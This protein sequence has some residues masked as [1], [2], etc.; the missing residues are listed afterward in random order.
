MSKTAKV[1]TVHPC[2]AWIDAGVMEEEELCPECFKAVGVKS[3]YKIIC[4]L[5]KQPAGATVGQLTTLLGLQQPTVT[6]HLNILKSIK[7]VNVTTKGR[8]RIYTLN[9]HAHCFE[10]CKIPY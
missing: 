5:G 1:E 10:E 4:A 3:R 7:A 6:H 9:R 8:E 2:P